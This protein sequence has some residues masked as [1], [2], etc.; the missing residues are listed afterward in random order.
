[1]VS[2]LAFLLN[3]TGSHWRVL[4]REVIWPDLCDV[5]LKRNILAALWRKKDLR[6]SKA[7]QE[8]Q[9]ADSC[10]HV[11]GDSWRLAPEWWQWAWW[12]VV[13]FWI[14]ISKVKPSAFADRPDV[15]YKGEN[16]Q[17]QKYGLFYKFTKISDP[18]R[19]PVS[20]F[21]GTSFC[22]GF[23]PQR[24]YF[25]LVIVCVCVFYLLPVWK[26]KFTSYLS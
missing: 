19:F 12:K 18:F 7:E 14:N 26:R 10:N 16:K 22:C 23:F 1:M 21:H 24:F 6:E 25:I 3:E 4:S 11:K 20:A 15:E 8:V 13:A 17:A 5:Y 9:L 2:S